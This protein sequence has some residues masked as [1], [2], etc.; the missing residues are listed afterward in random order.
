MAEVKEEVLSTTNIELVPIP[1]FFREN[2]QEFIKQCNS[3]NHL[4]T[5]LYGAHDGELYY[6]PKWF[7]SLLDITKE[8]IHEIAEHYDMT[9]VE[10]TEEEMLDMSK[11]FKTSNITVFMNIYGSLVQEY[12][13]HVWYKNIRDLLDF[14]RLLRIPRECI[15][16]I[17]AIRCVTIKKMCADKIDVDNLM[18][19][20]CK[21][22]FVK[23]IERIL[24]ET[25]E[26]DGV[27]VKTSL[28]SGKN[29]YRLKPM[30]SVVEVLQLLISSE[31]IS[32]HFLRYLDTVYESQVDL[33][34]IPWNDQIKPR[35]EFRIFIHNRRVT[36]ISQQKWFECYGFSETYIKTVAESMIKFY[37]EKLKNK[38]P[39]KNVTLDVW[40][41]DQMQTHLIECNSFGI[42]S[43]AGSSLFHW[44]RDMAML[45]N[46]DDI[47][48]VT[49]TV[50]YK[51][52]SRFAFICFCM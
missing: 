45:Y 36:G 14:P 2:K 37:N 46:E 47:T 29:E 48:Y 30:K 16:L 49:Y 23:N 4:E 17:L 25:D 18:N 41:D 1:I 38:L 8:R 7:R 42:F 39:Y 3:N 11:S 15:E 44:K 40:I 9:I 24:I 12:A 32:K 34:F 13:Y 31:E 22:D 52:L 33:V 28:T 51:K 5:A 21:T 43:P 50:P 35:N 10:K 26:G 6:D 20:L 27:F 19:K